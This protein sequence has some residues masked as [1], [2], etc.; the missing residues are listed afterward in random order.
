MRVTISLVVA[1]LAFINSDLS[2]SDLKSEEVYSAWLQMY[3]LKFQEAHITLERWQ[4][5]HPDDSLGPASDAAAYLFSELT[6]LGV[7]ESELFIDDNRFKN[8]RTWDPDPAVK[9]SFT[10]RIEQADQLADSALQKSGI[11]ARALFAKTLTYGLRADYVALIEGR[12]LKALSYTKSGRVYANR[13][14]TLQPNACDAYLGPGVENYLL[15]LKP[16][17]LR[18]LLRFT[19]SEVDREKGLEQLRKAALEG[20]YLEP[21]AK[22]LLA[23]A[24]LRDKQP[25]KARATLSELHERF[26]DNELYSAELNRLATQ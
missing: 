16:V 21:F 3:D 20:Y 8:R 4:E 24:A 1:L 11:D 19:G 9:N 18:V 2:G 17:A 5:S 12:G 10:K 25:E 14:M 15:S 13:L 6:R 26:P 7:L 22:L 23:V